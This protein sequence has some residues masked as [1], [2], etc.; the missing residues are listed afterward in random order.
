MSDKEEEEE[1]PYVEDVPDMLRNLTKKWRGKVVTVVAEDHE[2]Y[3]KKVIVERYKLKNNDLKDPVM[4]VWYDN[5]YY[6]IESEKDI[7]Y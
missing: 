6:I 2:L 1:I 5:K 3:D 4:E 7:Q